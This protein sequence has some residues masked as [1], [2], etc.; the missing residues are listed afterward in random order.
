MTRIAFLARVVCLSLS[1]AAGTAWFTVSLLVLPAAAD[2]TVTCSGWPTVV[3][4]IREP[5]VKAA[6]TEYPRIP[7]QPGDR[8]RI[9]ASGCVQTG[10]TGK[11][12]KRY[13]DPSGPNSDRLYHG[14]IIIKGA[15]ASTRFK[16]LP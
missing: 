9:S 2:E 13:V 8:I 3:C 14:L 12:W 4:T 16:D 10:G 1:V 5:N 11:T 7:I 15:M 6:L